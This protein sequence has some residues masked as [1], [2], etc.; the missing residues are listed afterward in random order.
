MY[1]LICQVLILE[2]LIRSSKMAYFKFLY[3]K[4]SNNGLF[5]A[6]NCK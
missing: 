6:D 2:K 1:M 5:N 4:I 3:I